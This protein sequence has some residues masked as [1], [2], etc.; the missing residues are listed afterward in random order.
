MEM[1][2]DLVVA[3]IDNSNAIYK[4][5][6]AVTVDRLMVDPAMRAYGRFSLGAQLRPNSCFPTGRSWPKGGEVSCIECGCG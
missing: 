3:K 4:L 5:P 1:N 2:P 6:R